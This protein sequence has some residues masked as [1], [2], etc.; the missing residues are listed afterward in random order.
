MFSQR[1]NDA[2]LT[3][4]LVEDDSSVSTMIEIALLQIEGI[5]VVVVSNGLEALNFFAREPTGVGALITDLHMP[6]MNGFDLIETIRA[7]ER[8]RH[9]PI[10]VVSGD[11]DP[12]TPV[13]LSSLEI[14][15][16]FAK[17]CSPLEIRQKLQM[18]LHA[19]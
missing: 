5:A 3:V 18:L 6:Y 1:N 9:L 2:P 19:D 7:H 12:H 8:Y 15:G 11:S 16:Y 17:P 14:N 13:R 4:L 10:L